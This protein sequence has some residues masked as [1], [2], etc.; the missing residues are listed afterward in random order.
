[1]LF[2]YKKQLFLAIFS[3]FFLFSCKN[4]VVVTAITKD[5]NVQFSDGTS[6]PIP[7]YHDST[8]IILYLV[9]H[10][11]K[12]K[13]GDD[14]SLT[15]EGKARAERLA[16][17]FKN[18]YLSRVITSNKKRTRETVDPIRKTLDPAIETIPADVI[19]MVLPAELYQE[20]RGRKIL[21]AHHSNT[22]PMW[23]DF[24]SGA[25]AKIPEIKDDDFGRFFIISTRQK[26][27]A[28]VMDLRY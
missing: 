25:K 5:G 14:P 17:I 19:P 10:A 11:E 9:R 15:A 18:A 7:H 24:T 1:M 6:R 20:D 28:E 22:V 27:D 13:T 4:E 21:V 16:A 26:G 8:A 12:E 3:L 23:I 2:F